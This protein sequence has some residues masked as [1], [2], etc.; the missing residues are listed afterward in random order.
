MVIGSA[1]AN[2][3]AEVTTVPPRPER[4]TSL[5][6]RDSE[7]RLLRAL[8]GDVRRGCSRSLVVRGE[9]GIGKTALLAYLVGSASDLTVVRANGV[10]SEMELP[11]ASISC[12][13]RSSTDSRGC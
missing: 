13:R 3:R 5:L 12:A 6:G 9:P 10:E 2:G 8:A 4:R 11:Y 7:R 1:S